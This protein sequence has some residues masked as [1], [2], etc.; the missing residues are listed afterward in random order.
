MEVVLGLVNRVPAD[1]LNGSYATLGPVVDPGALPAVVVEGLQ[2]PGERRCCAGDLTSNLFR[3]LVV[4]P[5]LDDA[6]LPSHGR[7]RRLVLGERELGP[8]ALHPEHVAHVTGVLERRPHARPRMRP[9]HRRVGVGQHG[10]VPDGHRAKS[11]RNGAALDLAVLVPALA[12][13][14]HTTKLDGA[15]RLSVVDVLARVTELLGAHPDV[16]RIE[17]AGSRAHGDPTALSDWDF[18]IHTTNAAALARD[19]PR[20]VA[21]L[22]PLVAQWDRLVDRAV[23][24]LVLPGPVKVDL[25]PGD[26]QHEIEPPWEPTPENLA[27]IDAHFW[28]WVLWL[29]SKFLHGRQQVVDEELR[30]LHRNLLGPLGVAPPPTTIDATVSEYRRAR[31]RLEREWNVSIGR[32]LGDEVTQALWRNRVI[33]HS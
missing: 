5:L 33:D 22:E 30:K 14:V 28:D 26:E 15:A 6:L 23:Y 12:A 29:G 11:F 3:L 19:L 18:H 27:A 32:R 8:L 24:M 31:D 20:L 13:P 17:L 16:G 10:L 9:Q 4:V 21:P 1:P 25:F 7:E 2:Q